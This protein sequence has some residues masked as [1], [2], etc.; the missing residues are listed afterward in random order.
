ME[1]RASEQESRLVSRINR[2]NSTG[3]IK[4]TCF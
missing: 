1:A 2:L 3:R 4:P